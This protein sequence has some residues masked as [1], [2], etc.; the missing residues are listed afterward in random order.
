[1]RNWQI[2]PGEDSGVSS[3]PLV[4]E[5]EVQI[6]IDLVQNPDV[7]TVGFTGSGQSMRKEPGR[8]RHVYRQLEDKDID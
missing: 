6:S 8:S 2:G 3:C 1:M 5:I 4:V 7:S